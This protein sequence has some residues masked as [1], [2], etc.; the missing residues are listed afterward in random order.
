MKQ[1]EL[2]IIQD[3]DYKAMTLK[4]LDQARLEDHIPSRNSRIGIKP[5]LVSASPAS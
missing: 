4:I 1:N 5:N 3:T 2:Y